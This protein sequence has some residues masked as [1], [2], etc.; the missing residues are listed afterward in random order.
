MYEHPHFSPF[1]SKT[2]WGNGA[3]G[4]TETPLFTRE[5]IEA[6]I[7]AALRAIGSM[8]AAIYADWIERGE[9]RSKSDE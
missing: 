9:Y 5:A 8:P 2:T 3:I 7:A 4:W 6:E 1:A